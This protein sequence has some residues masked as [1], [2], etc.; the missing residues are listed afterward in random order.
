MAWPRHDRTLPLLLALCVISST[1]CGVF[2]PSPDESTT[3]TGR[4][5]PLKST[6]TPNATA[7]ED[8]PGDVS[9]PRPR[10]ADFTNSQAICDAFTDSLFSGNPEVEDQSAPVKRAS[11]FT[12]SSYRKYFITGAPRLANWNTW[13]E[14]GAKQL[15]HAKAK[16]LGD[17]KP[18]EDTRKTNYR[19]AD[20]RV[21]PE[22]SAGN[23][24]GG[25]YRF[26]VYCTLVRDHGDWLVDDHSQDEI[27]P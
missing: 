3:P 21:V 15:N 22:D 2:G 5:A 7:T 27:D 11:R 12:S 17:D 14:A 16:H 4:K 18:P 20:R 8:P 6:A 13:R 23:A 9:T 1:G 24:V 25:T 26:A 10:K 19:L